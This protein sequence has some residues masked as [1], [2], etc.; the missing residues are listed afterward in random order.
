MPTYEQLLSNLQQGFAGQDFTSYAQ[1]QGIPVAYNQDL[2]RLLVGNTPVNM[3]NLGLENQEGK[4][5]G[6]ETT[7]Q[8]LLQPY[9]KTGPTD[10]TQLKPY[11]TP[12]W[13]KQYMKDMIAEQASPWEYNMEEDPSVIAA[14]E[15]LENSMAEMTGKRGF[16]YGTAQ[17]QLIN[18]AFNKVAPMFEEVAYQKQAD[19][20]QRQM[21]LANTI[22][23][24]DDMLANRKMA[25]N[26]LVKMKADFMLSLN[27]RDLE[28]F[29]VMLNQRRFNME[30]ELDEKR[31]D[32]EKRKQEMDLAWRKVNELGYADNEAAAILGVKP[33]TEA[34]WSKKLILQHK[35][36][37]ETMNKKNQY[38][39]KML[40]VNKKIE[41]DLI[42]EQERV[43]TESQM[44]LMEVEYGFKTAIVEVEEVYRRKLEAKREAERKAEEARI[45][46]EEEAKARAK[47]EKEAK[48]E[49]FDIQ[50]K[51][52]LARLKSSYVR[53][54]YI[55]EEYQEAASKMLYDNLKNGTID[56]AVYNR[57]IAEYWLTEYTPKPKYNE[58]FPKLEGVSDFNM[59][60]L[61][62]SRS[63]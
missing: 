62:L 53:D 47:A 17:Q 44:R 49:N 21:Q 23:Q 39:I 5:Y 57:L 22:M 37:I 25:E 7:Y 38:D 9:L 59:W 61:N 34:G 26:E 3:Q 20:Y 35:Q 63:Y 50:Y 2:N 27:Q 18:Q 15:Q 45:R 56:N 12:E 10:I 30:L 33:G 51:G 36:E 14:R 31:F 13:I 48:E 11:E 40:S 42:K 60:A 1:N 24:W 41:M 54:G 46:R 16:L 8:Q 55:P 43:K 32:L 4:L 28:I 19:R 29:K 52:M 6:S 58:P